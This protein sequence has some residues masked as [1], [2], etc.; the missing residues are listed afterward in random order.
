MWLYDHASLPGVKLGM[1]LG[2]MLYL[3]VLSA[4]KPCIY[5]NYLQD[6]ETYRNTVYLSKLLRNDLNPNEQAGESNKNY[7]C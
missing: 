4:T 5:S 7:L 2:M 6:T 3:I 1:C